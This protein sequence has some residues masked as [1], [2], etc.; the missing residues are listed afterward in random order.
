MRSST[1]AALL[2]GTLMLA[3]PAM[4]TS[5]PTAGLAALKE[6]NV[7]TFRDLNSSSHAQGKVW[8]GGNLTG[9][10]EVTQGGGSY[11]PGTRNS[12]TVVGNAATYSVSSGLGINPSKVQIGGNSTGVATMNTNGSVQTGG[13][14]NTQN[15]NPTA[16]KTYSAGVAGLKTSL[17]TQ[18]ASL[19]S[20]L[21]SLSTYLSGLSGTQI[22]NLNTALTYGSGAK[23]AVFTMSQS[24]FQ[25]QNANFN[26]LF[27]SVPAG[28]ITIINVA[29]TSLTEDQGAN[30]NASFAGYE[31]LIWNF[32][33]ATSLTVG[34]WAGTILAPKAL[35]TNR[36]GNITG[37]V[38][39]D[40]FNMQNQVHLSTFQGNAAN[41]QA[42]LASSVPAAVPEVGTW[43]M[44]VIGFGA[45]GAALR[46]RRR[47]PAAIASY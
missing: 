12:L 11:T 45:I 42:L 21:K 7:I 39:V 18:S 46:G 30:F 4:A 15:Y 19:V 20:D 43:A 10:L 31:N 47:Q 35:L 33:S 36:N 28:V 34:N 37:S 41:S 5:N 32:G 22:T 3:S 1:V 40:T 27:G 9:S 6:L 16:T 44:M 29:G 38:A 13:T 14:F 25:T 8:V 24:V 23:Y 2:L 26:T 17:Q